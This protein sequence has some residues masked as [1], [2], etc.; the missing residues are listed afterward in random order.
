MRAR[1]ISL[2]ILAVA[3]LLILALAGCKKK[4]KT[5]ACDGNDDCA[6]G[7]VCVN[8]QCVQCAAS[9]DCGDGKECKEGA[10]VAKAECAKDLDCPDGKVCQ[11]GACRPCAAD[12]ECGPGGQCLGGK[13]NRATACAADD[14]CADDEDCIDGYCQKPWLGGSGGGTCQLATVYFALDDASIAASERDRLD[15][16]AACIEKTTGKQVY[17]VGHTDAS[18]TDEYN[19]ALSERRAQT[20]ADYLARLG[21]D[22]ARLQIVPKGESEPS[23]M[24]EEKDRRVEFQ[25]R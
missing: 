16:N 5:P 6:D 3:A 9:A 8:K 23:G 11:A 10:C 25:W 13:C 14:D 20:V 1:T 17:V 12:G 15:G 19:I 18:G 7:L 2:A 22:P 4:P 24:G 21:T